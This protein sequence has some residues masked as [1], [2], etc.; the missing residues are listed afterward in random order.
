MVGLY[1]HRDRSLSNINKG[2]IT[3]SLSA[4]KNEMESLELTTFFHIYLIK[5]IASDRRILF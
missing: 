3:Q 1:I 2:V 5:K 4:Y